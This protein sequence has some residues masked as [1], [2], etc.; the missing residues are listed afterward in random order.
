MNKRT[1]QGLEQKEKMD[2]NMLVEAEYKR[3]NSAAD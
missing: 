1:L 2:V 3:K